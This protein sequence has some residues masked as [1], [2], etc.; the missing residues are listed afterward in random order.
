MRSRDLALRPYPNP[1]T[2]IEK[3]KT[4]VDIPK[5]K[6]KKL[7]RRIRS[8]ITGNTKGY[9]LHFITL[10]HFRSILISVVLSTIATDNRGSRNA[11][12]KS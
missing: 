11:P 12:E 6:K 2:K 3:K 7:S 4:P 9:Y 8:S 5:Y 10:L 1:S